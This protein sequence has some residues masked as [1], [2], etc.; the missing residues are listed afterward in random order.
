MVEY[1]RKAAHDYGLAAARLAQDYPNEYSGIKRLDKTI[2]YQ[3]EK[4]DTLDDVANRYRGGQGSNMKVTDVQ[5]MRCLDDIESASSQTASHTARPYNTLAVAAKQSKHIQRA[6][7]LVT[8]GQLLNRMHEV[9][10]KHGKTLQW[11]VLKI[12][13]T[14][15]EELKDERSK[16]SRKYNRLTQTER[17]AV[18]YTD[19]SQIYLSHKKSTR[20]YTVTKQGAPKEKHLDVLQLHPFPRKGSKAIHLTFMGTV[21]ALVGG[22]IDGE[23]LH[24]TTGTTGRKSKFKVLYWQMMWSTSPNTPCHC[25]THLMQSALHDIWSDYCHNHHDAI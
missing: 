9:A 12:I 11:Q 2:R 4:G 25:H 16:S 14:L 20:G 17:K 3:V 1:A 23:L 6:L 19:E 8:P 18:C 15:T 10:Q 24:I 21:N 5:V 22:G 7:E 13:R